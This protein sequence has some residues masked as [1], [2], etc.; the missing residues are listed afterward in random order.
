MCGFIALVNNKRIPVDIG[1]LLKEL[2]HRGPDDHGWLAFGASQLESKE[3][4]LCDAPVLLGHVRL[5]IWI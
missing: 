5:A 1:S 2:V 4:A 3:D